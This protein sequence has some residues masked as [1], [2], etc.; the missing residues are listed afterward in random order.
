MVPL[1]AWNT[2]PAKGGIY[3]IIMKDIT[4]STAQLNA[5]QA[6]TGLV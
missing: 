6:E 5:M 1:D 3:S 2:V 4:C